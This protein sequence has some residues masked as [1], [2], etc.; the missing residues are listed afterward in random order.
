MK[1]MIDGR[2][3][4]RA[5]DNDELGLLILGEPPYD[6]EP[7]ADNSARFT[8]LRQISDFLRCRTAAER[9][10]PLSSAVATLEASG[11][12]W[13]RAAAIFLRQTF[14]ATFQSGPPNVNMRD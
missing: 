13:A 5:W 2:R 12:G 7:H 10:R 8:R 14:G 4:K 1:G 9:E 6:Y 3:L 11:E